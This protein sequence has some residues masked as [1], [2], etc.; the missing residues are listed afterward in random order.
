MR[1]LWIT[2]ACL[3]GGIIWYL[4]G[5]WILRVEGYR[6]RG[7]PVMYDGKEPHAEWAKK[8]ER[9]RKLQER[10]DGN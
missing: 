7:F 1:W 10:E 4:L 9:A 2:L 3:A 5:L 6:W 8:M